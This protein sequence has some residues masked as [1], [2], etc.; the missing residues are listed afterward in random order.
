MFLITR[1]HNEIRN[2]ML[3]SLRNTLSNFSI[4]LNPTRNCALGESRSRAHVSPEPPEVWWCTP[5]YQIRKWS[6]KNS[7]L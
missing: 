7:D 5:S 1:I 2:T 4:N 3:R 6:D